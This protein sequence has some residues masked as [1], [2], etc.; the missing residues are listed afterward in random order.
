MVATQ[1]D[2]SGVLI[3]KPGVIAYEPHP[4]DELRF[5]RTIPID[6]DLGDE[7]IAEIIRENVR[8]LDSLYRWLGASG[9]GFENAYVFK[10]EEGPGSVQLLLY[11]KAVDERIYLKVLHEMLEDEKKPEIDLE[12]IPFEDHPED[13][14]SEEDF[15]RLIESGPRN[16]SNIFAKIEELKGR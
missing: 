9:L 15:K 7:K 5:Q 12:S 13:H 6:P 10:A 11:P 3:R 14:V 4:V 2:T 8:K 1:E 16:F